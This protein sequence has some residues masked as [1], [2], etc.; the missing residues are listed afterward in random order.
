MSHY[1]LLVLSEVPEH[2]EF[3][4]AP[5]FEGESEEYTRF[6]PATESKA[7]LK[8]MYREVKA[9]FNYTSFDDFLRRYCGYTFS[10]EHQAY[11]RYTNPDGKWDW[12]VEGGR[13]AGLLKLKPDAVDAYA[14]L[15]IDGKAYPGRASQ[16]KLRDID[17]STDPAAYAHA[18]RY[19]EINVEGMALGEDEKK[20]DFFCLYKPEY[21]LEQYGSKEDFAQ[22][23]AAFSTW[24][25]LTLEG[26]W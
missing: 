24:A 22:S 1:A 4:M 16:A 17:I 18:L 14:P 8:K 5:F 26:E 23:E 21:Y 13:W 20:D 25:L 19:W 11:G 6:V 10:D 12:Y 2:V 15:M 7:E 9:A 3:Q